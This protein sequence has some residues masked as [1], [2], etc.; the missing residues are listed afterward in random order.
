VRRPGAEEDG[1]SGGRA[2]QLVLGP[3]ALVGEAEGELAANVFLHRLPLHLAELL[4]GVVGATGGRSLRR[5]RARWKSSPRCCCA[6][7]GSPCRGWCL[8]TDRAALAS[9]GASVPAPS[10]APAPPAAAPSPCLACAALPSGAGA[11]PLGS[12]PRCSLPPPPL[13]RGGSE[14]LPCRSIASPCFCKA[15]LRASRSPSCSSR[16]SRPGSKP[17]CASSALGEASSV[18][19]PRSPSCPPRSS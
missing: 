3:L 9:S 16:S 14:V 18:S 5:C 1:F 11:S 2:T 13:F 19:P 8:A 10:P 6:L 7:R 12:C 17:A 4:P 15:L